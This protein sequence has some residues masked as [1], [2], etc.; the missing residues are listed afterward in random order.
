MAME[1]LS[2]SVGNEME[3]YYIPPNHIDRTGPVLGSGQYGTAIVGIY[4][5]TV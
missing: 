3:S 2:F 5:G 4:S 1:H